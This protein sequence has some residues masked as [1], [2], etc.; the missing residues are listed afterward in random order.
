M[1]QFDFQIIIKIEGQAIAEIHVTDKYILGYSFSTRQNLTLK[2][3]LN[4]LREAHIL[5]S[6]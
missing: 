3:I 5:G 4:L 2:E 6:K 1:E